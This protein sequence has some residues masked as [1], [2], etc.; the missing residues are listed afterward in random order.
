M[1]RE[2]RV[3]GL[4]SGSSLDGL[5]L[6]LCRFRID[7]DRADQPVVDWEIEVADTLAFSE[8][9]VSRLTHLPQQ[10]GLILAKTHTYFG[11]YQAELVRTFLDRTGARPDLIAAHGHTVFHAPERRMSIQIGD[12]AALAALTGYPVAA[13][14]RTQDVALDGQGA[15]LAP[16]ADRYLFGGYQAYLNLGGIANLSIP[17]PDGTTVAFDVTGANQLLNPLARLTG[18][19]YDA[20]GQLAATGQVVP[21][22]LEQLNQQPFF[23]QAPPK[24]LSNQWVQTQLVRPLLELAQT[25][26]ADRLR[27]AVTHTVDQLGSALDPF[28]AKDQ[29]FRLLATGGGAHNVFLMAEL[30]A[31]LPTVEM[32]V[33]APLWVDFKEA[34]LIAL[35]GALRLLELPNVLSSATGARR[36][37][38]SGAL[39]A[40]RPG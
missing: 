29:P 20:G 13:D 10:S 5:D 8:Q 33:P 2:L 14:F 19:A 32:V 7:T 27:T 17:R 37:S 6:A 15:P 28:I 1:I 23:Q 36:S 40:G 38:C 39:H 3:L 30:A 26:P 35:M 31:R 34:A 12:A 9:W 21:E 22:L 11:H 25:S 16:L 24:S 4:M 18:Q